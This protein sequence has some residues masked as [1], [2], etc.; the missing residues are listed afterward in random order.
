M[1]RTAKRM[2]SLIAMVIAVAGMNA[3]ISIGFDTQVSQT[4]KG[5]SSE[6][7]AVPM[8]P[9][10]PRPKSAVPMIPDPPRP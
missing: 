7:S 8:I 6:K 10:P 3:A 9:D 1:S 2:R 4:E 5:G